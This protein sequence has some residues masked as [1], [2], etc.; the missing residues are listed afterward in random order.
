MPGVVSDL[1]RREVMEKGNLLI[2]A[3][4]LLVQRQRETESWIAEQIW[5]AEERATAT[6]RVAADFEARLTAIEAHLARLVHDVEPLRDDA[7][8][9]ARLERLREQVA[10]LKSGADART[11]RPAPVVAGAPAS[12]SSPMA[13]PQTAPTSGPGVSFWQLLGPSPDGRF[14]VVLIGAGALAVLYA[15]L[16]QLRLA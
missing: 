8:V 11:S 5:Q 9:D 16:T 12:I 13:R 2:E 7:G 10:G 6:E 4:S 14:G 1:N 15:I 3:V